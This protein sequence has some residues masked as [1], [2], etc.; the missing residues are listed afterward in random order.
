MVK[1]PVADALVDS[2]FIQK[3]VQRWFR[4]Y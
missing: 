1:F 3:N 2:F 4:A